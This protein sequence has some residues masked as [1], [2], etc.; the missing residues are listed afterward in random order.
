[1]IKRMLW[2]LSE[3]VALG[4]DF[5]YDTLTLLNK[6]YGE[7]SCTKDSVIA[8]VVA[9]LALLCRHRDKATVN[10]LCRRLNVRMSTVQSRVKRHI[11]RRY[12]V[13][14]F[15]SLV[16]SA[17]I[18]KATV[19]RLGIFENSKRKEEFRV[20]KEEE[21]PSEELEIEICPKIIHLQAKTRTPSR[22]KRPSKRCAD[23]FVFSF[24]NQLDLQPIFITFVLPYHYSSQK[25]SPTPKKP[26][27]RKV[28]EEMYH[29]KGP[30]AIK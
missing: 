28:N 16:K 1:M 19:Y 7:I 10:R 26:L 12:H 20:Y 21:K 4:M 30:P 5:Y 25:Y 3:E 27:F 9:S 15:E 29:S 23:W 8:A 17:D 24:Q 2:G 13:P 11:I 6:L 14:E 18:V 22:F